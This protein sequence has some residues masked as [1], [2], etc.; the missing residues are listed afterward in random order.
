[1]RRK[2]KE[3]CSEMRFQLVLREGWEGR[4]G[5]GVN[6]TNALKKTQFR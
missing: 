6:K 3:T 5:C 1:M 4:E 2:K